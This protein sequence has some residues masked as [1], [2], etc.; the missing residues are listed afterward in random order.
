MR[1]IDRETIINRFSLYLCPILLGASVCYSTFYSLYQPSAIKYTIMFLV[2]EILLYI[3]FDKLKTKKVLCP[4][5]YTGMLFISWIA[6]YWLVST[7]TRLNRDWMAP[8]LWFFGSGKIDENQPLFL[9]AVFIGGGF[10]LTSILYYFTQIRYRAPGIMLSILFPFVIYARRH[11]AMPELMITIIVSLYL[12]VIVHNR[13]SDPSKPDNKKI[14]FKLD[15][16]YIISIALFVS[17]TGMITMMIERPTYISVLERNLNNFG[18]IG[19]T[20]VGVGQSMLD[21]YSD[22]STPRYG[23]K[24]YTGDPLFYLE[25][26]GTEKVYYL[27]KQTFFSFNGDVWTMDGYSDS[28]D[29]RYLI[30]NDNVTTMQYFKQLQRK[31]DSDDTPRRAELSNVKTAKVFSDTFSPIYLPAAYGAVP[32]LGSVKGVDYQ[33][34]E[35]ATIF[36]YVLAADTTKP[37]NDSFNFTPQSKAVYNF[38]LSVGYTSEEYI[39]FLSQFQDSEAQLLL[40]DYNTALAK[41]TSTQHISEKVSQLAK[42]VTEDCYS[43]MEK[44]V[45][46]SNYFKENDYVYDEEYEPD[47]QAID[48]FIFEGKTGVCT[49]YATAMTLMARSVGLPARYVEGFSCF[50]NDGEQRF[51]I[52]DKHAHAFVEVYIPGTGWLTFDPTVSAYMQ[53][54]EKSGFS[55]ILPELLKILSRF[56]VIIAVIVMIFLFK[57]KDGIIEFVFR[58]TQIFRDPEQKTLKLYANLIRVVGCSTNSDYRSYTVGNMHS[59]LLENRGASPEQLL[60]LFEKT[61]FGGYSPTEQEYK[62]AYGE[63]KKCYKLMKKAEKKR[64][65]TK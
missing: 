8:M 54:P 50:E 10:F 62:N 63:Y 61:A 44:A 1:N 55:D 13:I 22:T 25:T 53:L 36:R 43:D 3:V 58:F 24:D 59:Y 9:N 18:N 48:Y 21:G 29:D 16:A 46:L 28:I 35:D 31:A 64:K 47:D 7:G 57:L 30:E 38:A 51:V 40:N 19:N 14:N 6:V 17:F 2:G 49:S 27:R 4:L 37:L 5:I 20:E 26:D 15:R 23:S 65:N 41:Y 33:I 39:N 60:Q 42:K 34:L 56:A 32:N 52:R 12:A 11:E 45:V